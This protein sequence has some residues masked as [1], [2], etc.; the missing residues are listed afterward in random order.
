MLGVPRRAS[1]AGPLPPGLVGLVMSRGPEQIT[2]IL[3][4]VLAGAAYLPI[5]AGLPAERRQ[6]MLR[7]G[8][9]R[10][11]LTDTAR[12]EDHGDRNVLTLDAPGEPDALPGEAPAALPGAGPDDLAYVLYTSGTTGEPKGVMVT[13]RNVANVVADCRDRFGIGP[14]DRFFAISAFNFDLSV[15]DV[16]GALSAGAA[17]VMPDPDKAVDPAHWLELS[18]AAGVT[19]WNSVPA[20]VSLLHDQALAETGLP[21][22]L[23]LVMMSG[24]RIPPALPAALRRLKDDLEVISLGGPTETTIWNILHPVGRHEDGSESIP[25]GRPNANNRAY[26]LDQDGLDAPDW[27]TGEICAAGTGLARGYWGDEQRTAE[28][29]FHDAHRGERLYRTGDLGRYLPDGEIQIMGRSDFQI[30]VN[31][32]RIEAGEVETRLVAHDAV[33]QAVVTKASGARGDLLVAH[34]V[35]AGDARPGQAELRQ[36]LRRDLP[37]YMTPSAVVW[38]EELPLTRNGKVD[39]TRLTTM[40]TDAPAAAAGPAP[41]PGAAPAS[42]LESQV[43]GIWSAVLK[44]T[45]VGLD[46]NLRD[47]G[48]DS[49]SAARILTSVRKEFRTTIPLDAMYEMGTVRAMAGH[50][51]AVLAERAEKESAPCP[52][53]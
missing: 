34:L 23:R 28:R 5:D 7:D 6:Y 45:E 8:R 13:H 33:R 43:A 25:Y 14:A 42:P 18:T 39:R 17:L 16:F 36:A 22:A 9:V 27:V 35:P 31:G 3:A 49:I 46:D 12:P 48:G 29:F 51:A 21:P 37:D 20:I 53:R 24:D 10:C 2:G 32:Y 44:G 11:V 1:S 30:K 4:T 50:L 40:A 19:V 47:L 38:H 41:A 26:I 52:S 15:W